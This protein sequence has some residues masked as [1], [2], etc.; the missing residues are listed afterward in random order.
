[1]EIW[2]DPLVTPDQSGFYE[3]V[4]EIVEIVQALA[5]KTET[6]T[7]SIDNNF[8][9]NISD[10]LGSLQEILTNPKQYEYFLTCY[11]VSLGNLIISS[12]ILIWC[13]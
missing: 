5:N 7:S 3:N 4:K 11:F 1:M 9:F 8:N 10:P 2:Q 13:I 6:V 12:P